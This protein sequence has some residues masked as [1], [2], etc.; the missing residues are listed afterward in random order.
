MLLAVGDCFSAF[1]LV[2]VVRELRARGAPLRLVFAASAHE[3]PGLR[4]LLGDGDAAHAHPAHAEPADFARLTEFLVGQLPQRP[5]VVVVCGLA[6][7]TPLVADAA[8]AAGHRVVMLDSGGRPFPGSR[9]PDQV[10]IESLAAE[11]CVAGADE[12][13]ALLRAGIAHDAVHVVGD[14][15]AEAL[16]SNASTAAAGDGLW[17]GLEHVDEVSPA[18]TGA[19]RAAVAAAGLPARVAAD[20]LDVG[21]EVVG[22]GAQAELGAALRARAIVTDS[23]GHQ[24]LAAAMGTPCVVLPHR[25][26]WPPAVATGLV[27][28]PDPGH[29]ALAAAVQWAVAQPGGA[30]AAATGAAAR[31]ADVLLA[32]APPRPVSLPSDADASGRTFGAEEAALV[33]LVLQRGTLNSTRGTFVTAF[34]QRFAKWLGSKHAIACASGS[35]AVHCAIAALRLQPGDEVITTPITDMGAITPIL[36]EGAVP[37]FADVEPRTLNVTR[38]TIE[39]ALTPRTRAIVVTHLFGSPCAMDPILALAAERGIPVIE[40]AAQAFGATHGGRKVGVLGTLGTFSLQQGKHITSG[41]GGIVVTDDPE[42]ARRVFLFVN[43]AWGYGDPKPDH[44][45]PALNYRLTELQGAVLC[46][47]LS[48]LDDVVQARRDV[49]AALRTAL[50][51]VP[52]LTLPGDPP[53]GTHSW[54]KFAFQVDPAV[55]PGGAIALG[56]RMQQAGIACV[57]R[58]I[59]KPAFECELFADWKRSPVTWLPLQQ[60][61]RREQPQPLFRRADF[62]GAVQALEHVIVLPINERYQAVHVGHVAARIAAAVEE[63]R[64]G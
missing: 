51:A 5:G 4:E 9:R 14:L 62:P 32:P 44:Y 64:R 18:E 12:A 50:A 57:P 17:L 41:E 23:V 42:L 24:R 22:R 10:V 1:L 25:E 45:F 33:A 7:A 63:L 28:Q 52:G 3:V 20:V 8:R 61:P 56:K 39:R 30:V 31:I 36:Y 60:N 40:D 19:L 37:V 21:I 43:K 46:A 48:K 59:Q 13:R 58:Y 26:L 2:P 15:V 53:H 47:Q 35:A 16:A 29:A 34:E 55:V 38:A 49:A 6:L 54:W 11:H 27:R